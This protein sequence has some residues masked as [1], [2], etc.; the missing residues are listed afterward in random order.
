MVMGSS[1]ILGT[2]L[3]TLFSLISG[4]TASAEDEAMPAY[5]VD[6]NKN[7]VFT[8]LLE[9]LPLSQTEVF[10]AAVDYLNN[11]YKTSRYEIAHNLPEKGIVVGT[12]TLNSFYENN[13]LRSSSIFS[14]DYQLRVDA[15][16]GRARVQVILT[17]YK[18]TELSDTGNKK[19]IETLISEVAPV[20]DNKSGNKRKFKK[21][22]EKLQ[23]YVERVLVSTSQSL[24]NARPAPDANDNW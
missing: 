2:V 10:Q 19:V 7:V 3:L 5:E 9:G 4:F 23:E 13:G 6:R 12:A 8:I 20:S 1:K 24:K 22:F 17:D 21:A 18:E 16:D 15:K 11:E 14:V